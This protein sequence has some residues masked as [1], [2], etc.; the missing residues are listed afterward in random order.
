MAEKV[1]VAV[2]L[3]ATRVRVCLGSKSGRILRRESRKMVVDE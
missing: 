2:D 3:G 1:A